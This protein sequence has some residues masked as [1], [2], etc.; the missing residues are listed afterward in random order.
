MR[1]DTNN[2]SNVENN[3][4]VE[5]AYDEM[6][7]QIDNDM[8]V[9]T[10]S[11]RK[12]LKHVESLLD[13]TYKGVVGVDVLD[14]PPKGEIETYLY[15]Q[16]DDLHLDLKSLLKFRARVTNNEEFKYYNNCYDVEE[17]YLTI[18]NGVCRTSRSTRP[19]VKVKIT[20]PRSDLAILRKDSPLAL[21]K[22]HMEDTS[23]KVGVAPAVAA[24]PPPITKLSVTQYLH[25]KHSEVVKTPTPAATAPQ[26]DFNAV[27]FLEK[28]QKKF[29]RKWD[30]ICAEGAFYKSLMVEDKYPY[31]TSTP[32]PKVPFNV[33]GS[34]DLNMRVGINQDSKPIRVVD[35]INGVFTCTICDVVILDRYSLQDHWYSVKHKNNM[36]QV[37]VI[38]GL[39]ERIAMNRPVLQEMVD[40]FTLCP[41]L[42]LDYVV[43]ILAG[44]LEPSY[45]CAVCSVDITMSDLMHHLTSLNH[46]LT[47]IKEFFEVAWARFST[48]TDFSTWL[49]SDF[50]C[51]DIVVNKIDQ[52]H[53]TKKQSVVVN[54]SEL[55]E[56]VQRLR[57]NFYSARRTELDTFF[58]KNLTPVEPSKSVLK[59]AAVATKSNKPRRVTVHGGVTTEPAELLPKDTGA[60]PSIST[61]CLSNVSTI[62]IN[63]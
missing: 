56:T 32:R 58:R 41:L 11:P 42:G 51:L 35:K 4:E 26:K 52:V 60:W 23:P 17:Q 1:T 33:K 38:A 25:A 3:Q 34:N 22:V 18:V 31:F 6:L 9:N 2:D 43:E 8:K 39:E 54:K 24:P 20:N 30:S 55:G 61:R 29:I 57:L 14:I 40:Q 10:V 44:H 27:K 7:S 19:C 21:I 37:Q 16:D 13:R 28:R 12:T 59:P 49:N 45:H 63:I 36:K 5:N 50:E 47:F 53:G 62:N 48:I 15:L 46:V